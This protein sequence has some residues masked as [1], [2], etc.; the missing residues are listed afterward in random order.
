MKENKN[1]NVYNGI[2]FFGLLQV[3]FIALKVAKV[4]NWSWWLVF[5]PTW[6]DLVICLIVIIVVVVMAIII[7]KQ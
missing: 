6:I 7:N 3:V 4:I 1:S 5:L 2:G